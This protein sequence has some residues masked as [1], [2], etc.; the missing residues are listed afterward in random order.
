MRVN[1]ARHESVH[2]N[3][4]IE[5]LVRTKGAPGATAK[6]AAVR[7]NPPPPSP[8][9]RRLCASSETKDTLIRLTR[10]RIETRARAAE[11]E[12]GRGGAPPRLSPAR[13]INSIRVFLSRG[14]LI[15]ET[16]GMKC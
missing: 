1:Y 3:E 15:I 9:E 16:P 8:R 10:A 5:L 7:T 13:S 14:P 6:S 12:A 11:S 4:R 2:I